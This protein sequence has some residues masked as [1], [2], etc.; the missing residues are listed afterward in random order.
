MVKQLVE[1]DGKRIQ[2]SNLDKLI[3]PIPALTKADLIQY[4]TSIGPVALKY[5]SGRPLTLTRYPDGVHNH[6]FYQ[7][8]CPAYA[9]AWVDRIS[10]VTDTKT[11]EYIICNDLATLVWLGNQAVIEIHPATYCINDPNRPSFAIID[12]DPAAPSGFDEARRV[13][14]IIR[15][16]LA[17]L[18]LRGYPKTSGATGIHIYIPLL[19]KYSFEQSCWLVEFIGRLLVRLEPQLVTNE[20]LV[21]KRRGVYIDH[22]QN[23]PGKTIVGVYS[24]RP[25]PHAPVSTAI[26]WDELDYIRPEDF[27]I[28]T[29]P[30]RIKAVGDLFEPVLTDQQSID[31]ILEFYR[32]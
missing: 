1:V 19:P 31:Q 12:L 10:V 17:E 30:Q 26:S 24:P 6:G 9:P 13:A 11:I 5:W 4:F 3:W 23:L 27:T 21:K 29:V 2:L 18:G 25:L 8:N 20:R 28:T 7:K 22:L 16:V 32:G 15:N 14:A